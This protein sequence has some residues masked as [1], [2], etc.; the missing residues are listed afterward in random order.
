MVIINMSIPKSNTPLDASL[1]KV[2]SDF[3][4]RIITQFFAIK[5]GLLAGNDKVVGLEAGHLCE[6]VLRLLQKEVNGSSTPFGKNIG[7]FADECRKLVTSSNSQVN[8]SLRTVI[9]RALV[10]IYTM[11]SKR[12]IGHV[13]GDVDANRIDSVTIA[14]TCDWIVC[15]LIRCFHG[16]SLEEAQD[17]VDSLTVRNMT[18]IWDVGGKKRVLKQGLTFKDQVLLLCYQEPTTAILTEDVFDWVEYSNLS[19]FKSKVL[20]P[21]HKAR[22]IEFDKM[23]QCVTISPLGVQEVEG[24]IL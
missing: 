7:N 16:L 4:R 20:V 24:R 23:N 10:F 22:L 5:A 12:G 15:E 1:A 19:V 9:P 11:R 17:V 6:T 18:E 8:E 3:R 21:L 14:R 2:P 13:G